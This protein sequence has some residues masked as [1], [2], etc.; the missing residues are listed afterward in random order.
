MPEFDKD[1]R[2][3]FDDNEDLR[4]LIEEADADSENEELWEPSDSVI[5][6][7]ELEQLSIRLPKDNLAQLRSMAESRRIGMT[8][9]IRVMVREQLR[10]KAQLTPALLNSEAQAKDVAIAAL[11]RQLTEMQGEVRE[12]RRSISQLTE[13]VRALSVS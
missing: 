11:S 6:R 12:A 9:L 10:A 1:R 7:P 4:A 8:T 2:S 5:V 3:Q 13:Q